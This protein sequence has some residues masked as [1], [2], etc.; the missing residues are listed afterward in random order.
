M[1]AKAAGV[2]AA[3]VCCAKNGARSKHAN[4]LTTTHSLAYKIYHNKSIK[5]TYIISHIY[6]RGHFC[7]AKRPQTIKICKVLLCKE[8]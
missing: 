2:C 6:H 5:T 4:T 3:G 8:A 1:R 7:Q